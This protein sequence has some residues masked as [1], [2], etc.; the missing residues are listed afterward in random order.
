M[1]II[2]ALRKLKWKKLEL[3]SKYQ[4]SQR[5]IAKVL[6]QKKKKNLCN[7]KH[8]HE[9]TVHIETVIKCAD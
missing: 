2:P 4:V 6:S 5:L 7:M 1:P 9:K 3:P 8:T